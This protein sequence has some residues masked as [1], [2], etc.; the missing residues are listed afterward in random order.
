MKFL[1]W[2][3]KFGLCLALL[4]LMGCPPSPPA[5]PPLNAAAAQHFLD[6]WNQTYCN[7]VEFYGFYQPGEEGGHTRV[8]YVSLVNPHEPRQ[9]KT[10]YTAR[11][12]V[13]TRPDGRQQ[14]FLTSLTSHASGLSLLKGWD[15]LMI[16]VEDSPAAASR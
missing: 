8:A 4:A 3:L 11:F 12:Q 6:T 1:G 2:R 16:A 14:W 15:N 10:V 5:L 7:V 9:K 13:L